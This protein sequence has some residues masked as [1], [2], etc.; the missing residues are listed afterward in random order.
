MKVTV[1]NQCSETVIRFSE[2][3]VPNECNNLVIRRRLQVFFFTVQIE[4]VQYFY[5]LFDLMTFNKCHMCSCGSSSQMECRAT[6]NSSVVLGFGWGY[7]TP[8]AWRPRCSSPAGTNL[9]NFNKPQRDRFVASS[10]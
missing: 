8:P 6:F 10:A 3:D 2:P 7:F 1:R 4:H 5:G 9:E